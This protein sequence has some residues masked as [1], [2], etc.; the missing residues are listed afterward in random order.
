MMAMYRYLVGLSLLLAL[1]IPAGVHAVPVTGAEATIP[2]APPRLSP[3]LPKPKGSE[4]LDSSAQLEVDAAR[5]ALEQGDLDSAQLAFEQA[6]K[7]QPKAYTPNL[8]LADVAARRGQ[9]AEA[10]KFM[11][12]ALA[13]APKSAEV[14]ASAGRLAIGF[15][16]IAEGERQLQRAIALDPK[17]VTPYTDLG[18]A[19]L[20]TR[21]PAEAAPMFRKAIA[22][23]PDHPG[24]YFGLGRALAAQRDV[25]GASAA[26]KASA[27]RSPGSPLPLIALAELQWSN[28]DEAAA[29]ATL[30]SAAKASPGDPRAGM[31]RAQFMAVKGDRNGAMIS[32]T[33]L[34][35]STAAP[36]AGV[37]WYK[38]GE[39]QQASNQSAQA[40]TS[41]QSAVRSDP[42]L[43]VAHNNLAWLLAKGGEET[44]RA[45][46]HATKA[47]N[48]QPG[49]ADYH[50]TLGSVHAARKEFSDAAVSFAR[51][52]QLAP[53]VPA[54][55]Y[56]LG[57]AYEAA[58][59]PA[60][61]TT[62][63]RSALALNTPFAEEKNAKA[64]LAALTATP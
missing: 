42:D 26:F 23:A 59:Q 39:L 58:G 16:K 22:V 62:S 17:F 37:V 41:Y 35:K 50:D 15:G 21:R 29:M 43:A 31:T 40:V 7:I 5:R 63:Y 18:E 9:R 61:A 57:L 30:D 3:P 10:E 52:A 12:Q 25:A 27:E 64:R 4:M 19:Y 47:V 20:M 32:L 8:G 13:L 54:F 60:K 46:E 14:A 53:K 44:R 56:R 11:Q 51:A 48:L 45:L 6:R 55:Q 1:G 24:A 33:A 28:G 34:A 36:A 2:P 38:L 49:V